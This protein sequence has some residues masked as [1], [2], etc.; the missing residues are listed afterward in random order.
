MP[1]EKY[2]DIDVN[3]I[4]S[5]L[6]LQDKTTTE[7]KEIGIVEKIEE[8]P[9]KTQLNSKDEVNRFPF[10]QYQN[11]DWDIEHIHAKADNTKE[12][13]DW[14]KEFKDWLLKSGND[15]L[16]K[17]YSTQIEEALAVEK[18]DNNNINH[19]KKVC[20]NQKIL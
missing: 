9:A 1:E 13:K 2:G 12:Q 10:Y 15:D 6:D 14:L 17:K 8:D 19:Y 18:N 11:I 16:I 3:P 7:I 5:H 20:H 4:E